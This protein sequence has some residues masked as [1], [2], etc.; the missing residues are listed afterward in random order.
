MES[1]YSVLPISI[2]ENGAIIVADYDIAVSSCLDFAQWMRKNPGVVDADEL[3]DVARN[4]PH[5]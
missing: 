1:I 3:R 5:G 2:P 4:V